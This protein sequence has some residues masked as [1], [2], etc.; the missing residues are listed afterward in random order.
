[1]LHRQQRQLSRAPRA[2]HPRL[3][4]NLAFRGV[5]RGNPSQSVHVGLLLVLAWGHVAIRI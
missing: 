3:R 4:L 2:S 1:M 5:I